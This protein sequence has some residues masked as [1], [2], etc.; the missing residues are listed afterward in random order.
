M[1]TVI[2]GGTLTLNP[3]KADEASE[4]FKTAMAETHKEAGN[5]A[6]NFSKDLSNPGVFHFFEKWESQEV[7]DAHLK[8]P[9]MAAFM[10]AM[11]SLEVSNA[12]A[13]KYDVSA[14]SSIM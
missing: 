8:T 1:G 12:E 10:A 9:H 2:V 4:V 5:I 6:Y 7:L 11:G 3:E 14:E 13:L